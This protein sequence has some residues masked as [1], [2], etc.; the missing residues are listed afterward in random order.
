MLIRV[1]QKKRRWNISTR[2][3]EGYRCA[4]RTG[5]HRLRRGAYTAR[6]GHHQLVDA[7]REEHGVIFGVGH[8]ADSEHSSACDLAV[9]QTREHFVGFLDRIHAEDG[10]LD[11]HGRAKN[12]ARN[13]KG[14]EREQREL[15][16]YR[17]ELRGRYSF[18]V[19]ASRMNSACEISTR[20]DR[21]ITTR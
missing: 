1:R 7:R 6:Y 21:K 10:W 11:L 18:R 15:A 2:S 19:P 5:T 9:T 20:T 4:V 14:C 3:T 8:G 13:R 16:E 12:Y 17:S